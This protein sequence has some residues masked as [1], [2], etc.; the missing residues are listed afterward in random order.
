MLGSTQIARSPSMR[1]QRSKNT[2]TLASNQGRGL[3]M[4]QKPYLGASSHVVGDAPGPGLSILLHFGDRPQEHPLTTWLRGPTGRIRTTSHGTTNRISV[5]LMSCGI[6]LLCIMFAILIAKIS[7][8]FNL[9]HEVRKV[10]ECAT[11][12]RRIMMS[13][14]PLSPSTGVPSKFRPPT[15]ERKVG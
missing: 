15:P 10:S 12:S 11:Q 4:E 6:D 9:M 3:M 8:R 7:H 5:M 1:H 13:T 2:G 14:S